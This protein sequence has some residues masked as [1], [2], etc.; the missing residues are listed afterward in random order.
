MFFITP[1]L[2]FFHSFCKHVV[3][4]MSYFIKKIFFLQK[5]SDFIFN[6]FSKITLFQFFIIRI[7]SFFHYFLFI[8]RFLLLALT[9]HPINNKNTIILQI[10]KQQTR[11]PTVGCCCLFF[12]L[13]HEYDRGE[14]KYLKK[15]QQ[16]H[17]R[18]QITKKKIYFSLFIIFVVR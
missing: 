7:F 17:T 13:F 16:S 10:I 5:S 8:Y 9:Q 14:R 18:A 4:R 12:L 11:R 6:S 3:M 15:I 2:P 1:V